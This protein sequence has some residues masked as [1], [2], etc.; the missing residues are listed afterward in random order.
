MR[1]AFFQ[2]FNKRHPVF[3]PFTTPIYSNS[4]FVILAYVLEAI[5]GSTFDK[6]MEGDVFGPLGLKFTST[7]VPDVPGRG[8]IPIGDPDWF[9]DTGD[10][11]P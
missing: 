10:T 9:R 4:A 6:I 3:A 11:A 5:T 1:I 2:G 7:S 8:V